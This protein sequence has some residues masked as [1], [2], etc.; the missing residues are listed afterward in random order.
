MSDRPFPASFVLPDLVAH[1][2]YPLRVNKHCYGVARESE[3]WLLSGAKL[4]PAR[5]DKFMGLKAGELTAACYP[6][7]DPYHLRVCDDFMNYLFNLDD[8][9]DEFDLDDTYGLAKC[10]LAAMRDPFT[11][12]T[13]KKA[14]LMTKS[15]FSRFVRTAGPG[16]TERFIQNM[17]LFFQSVAQQTQDRAQGVIP[18]MESYLALRRDNSGCKPCFQLTE[19]AAGIDLPEEVVQHPVIQSLEEAS[20]DLVT[21][22]NDI[23]S[24]NVEQSRNDTFNLVPVI[25]HEKGFSL[26][27]AVDFVGDLCKK[28]IDR[29]EN[30]KQRV[31][32]WGPE[33]DSQVQIYIDGLQN[34][35]VG[36]YCVLLPPPLGGAAVL[37]KKANAAFMRVHLGSLHWSFDS[38]RYFGSL[39]QEIKKHREVKL[40]PKRR[41]SA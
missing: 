16:C 25:M 22:S 29:F 2:Q 24:F 33:L 19:F 31:P 18:D 40:L 9:L 30:D 21:W 13:D 15:F 36:T 41:K 38:T 4:S 11:F 10:C 12:E 20:N 27:E 14:G 32:S 8:W 26:Q 1:C 28:T 35:I 17:D 39:G 3:K 7:A 34:W 5:A 37:V 23:F 6:D